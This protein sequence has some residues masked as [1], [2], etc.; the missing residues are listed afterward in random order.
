MLEIC[1]NE[2]RLQLLYPV[3]RCVLALPRFFNSLV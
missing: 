2:V 3:V 1:L